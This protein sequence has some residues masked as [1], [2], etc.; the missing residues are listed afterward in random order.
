[1][2][3]RQDMVRRDIILGGQ[4][5]DVLSGGPSEDWIFGGDGNDVL[6]GGLDRQASDLLFGGEGDD[7]FQVICDYLPL[8]KGSD[9]TFLPTF[10]DRFD[11]EEGNDRVL[12]L[13]GDYDRLGQSVPDHLA[14]RYN[15]ILHRYEISALVWD[16]AN[17]RFETNSMTLLRATVKATDIAP[18]DGVIDQDTTLTLNVGGELFDP[19]TIERN[20]INTNI[21]HLVDDINDALLAADMYDKVRAG[22]SGQ[23]L[24]LFA[25]NFVDT[26]TVVAGSDE[27]HFDDAQF[28]APGDVDAYVQTY[29]FYQAIDV[30]RT[31]IDTRAG[32]DEVRGDAEYM[33]PLADGSGYMPSEYGIKIGNFQEG[34]HI[35]SLDIRGGDGN[36]RLF[37]GDWHDTIDGGGGSDFVAGGLGD[38]NITGGP[39]AD[40]LLG[41]SGVEPDR[42]EFITRSG[43]DGSNN[44][45]EFASLIGRIGDGAVLSDLS[46]NR[47]DRGDWYIIPTPTAQMQFGDI[48]SAHLSRKMISSI[49]FFDENGDPDTN[50]D[51][52]FSDSRYDGENYYLFAAEQDDPA[53]E[54]SLVPVDDFSGVPG[55]YMLHVVNPLSFAVRAADVPDIEGID[56]VSSPVTAA[57]TL[58]VDG[59]ET[60][61][62][63][64]DV[65]FDSV[66]PDIVD[67]LN[68]KFAN[69]KLDASDPEP[70]ADAIKISSRVFA[71]EH[72]GTLI[73][74]LRSAGE[75]Q[76]NFGPA[77]DAV[78][79]GF[80][81]G[82]D[83][84]GPVDSMGTY[85]ITFDGQVDDL[86]DI[87]AD[88]ADLN[89]APVYPGDQAA[90]IPVG[91]INND[92]HGDFIVSIRDTV[93]DYNDYLNSPTDAHPHEIM[94]PSY[95]RVVF[96]GPTGDITPDGTNSMTLQL[97]GPVLADSFGV[98]SIFASPGDYDGDGVDDL[99]VLVTNASDDYAN[100]RPEFSQTGLYVMFGQDVWSES[101]NL[102]GQADVVFDGFFRATSLDGIGD[103]T[104]DGIDD[105]VVGEGSSGA[106]K[107]HL[108]E[109]AADRWGASGVMLHADFENDDGGF[110]ADNQVGAIVDGLWHESTGRSD[111]P[112]HS[113]RNS[114]YFGRDED[115]SGGG[116]YDVGDTAG[117]LLTPTI[118]ID[119]PTDGIQ[120][121][122]NYFIE[123]ERALSPSVTNYD[124]AQ[125]EI[126]VNGGAFVP[127]SNNNAA[128]TDPSEHWRHF[129]IE[130]GGSYTAGQTLR[131]RF[132][133][134]TVD[135]IKN[136]YEGWYVDDVTVRQTIDVASVTAT[137]LEGGLL[138]FRTGDVTADGIN[139]FAVVTPGSLLFSIPTIAYI[140]PGSDV[141]GSLPSGSITAFES[142]D[143]G[144]KTIGPDLQVAGDLN[145]D[146]ADDFLMHVMKKSLGGSGRQS[147]IVLGYDYEAGG[148]FLTQTMDI[149]LVALGDISGD[150][151]CDLAGANTEVTDA[152]TEDGLRIEHKVFGVFLSA[153]GN[154]WL[155]PSAFNVPDMI[156]EPGQAEYFNEG[157]LYIRTGGLYPLG[158]LN[159]DG[160]DDF[161]MSDTLGGHSHVFYGRAVTESIPDS[162]R[163]L[164]SELYV[165]EL[166]TPDMFAPPLADG[167]DVHESDDPDIRDAF[168]VDG[169]NDEGHLSGSQGIGDFNRDGYQDVMVY[170]DGFAYIL[171]GPVKLDGTES[172]GTRCE[173]KIDLSNLGRVQSGIGD[174]DGDG[175]D[176][177]MFIRH[178]FNYLGSEMDY[179]V[180]SAIYGN[181]DPRRYYSGA[182]AEDLLSVPGWYFQQVVYE[183]EF[184]VHYPE[185]QVI[186]LDW[187]NKD[188]TEVLVFSP[189][190]DDEMGIYGLL[191]DGDNVVRGQGLAAAEPVLKILAGQEDPDDIAMSM[192]GDKWSEFV[193]EEGQTE[194]NAAVA[195]VN[196]D[197]KD[198][199][200]MA[201]PNAWDVDHSS[202]H[203]GSIGRVYLLEGG[204]MGTPKTPA[205][206]TVGDE[207]MGSTTTSTVAQG[208]GFGDVYSIGDLNLDAYD[209]FAVVS[210]VE[211]LEGADGAAFVYY[212]SETIGNQIDEAAI[213]VRRAP[214][215]VLSGVA[216]EGPMYVTSG[217]FDSDDA[218]DLAIGQTSWEMT[219]G[220]RV[221]D[222]Q[223]RG[224]VHVVWDPVALGDEIVLV[225]G[226]SDF[227]GDG[228][229]DVQAVYGQSSHDQFGMLSNTVGMDVNV[230]Y[231]DDLMIGSAMA[232]VVK[233]TTLADA[234]K[235]Y[236]VYGSPRRAELAFDSVELLSNRSFT[237][238]GGVIVDPETGQP[239]T[240]MDIDGNN[241]GSL[242]T[243]YYTLHDTD[244]DKWYRFT[245]AGD[246]SAGDV[247]RLL[248]E[249]Y[250][251]RVVVFE[252]AG[253]SLG[254]N[255]SDGVFD[256]LPIAWTGGAASYTSVFE[257]DISSLL[258]SLTDPASIDKVELV[259]ETIAHASLT[260][261]RPGGFVEANG[262]TFFLAGG[263]AGDALWATDGTITGTRAL[264]GEDLVLSSDDRE[265]V[266]TGALVYFVAGTDGHEELWASDGSVEGTVCI[267][268]ELWGTHA[269]MEISQ[270]TAF[271][272]MAYFEADDGSGPRLYRTVPKGG[273]AY[274]IAQT[275]GYTGDFDVERMI[276]G[277]NRLYI[278]QFHS[279]T[280]GIDTYRIYSTTGSTGSLS[281]ARGL[282]FYSADKIRPFENAA[283][284]D[285][286]V[287]FTGP[288]S[289]GPGIFGV[290]YRSDG[291]YGGTVRVET[292]PVDYMPHAMATIDDGHALA[293][294][295]GQHLYVTD[296]TSSG[297]TIRKSYIF[298][299]F[300]GVARAASVDSGAYL[301]I[302]GVDIAFPTNV[303][304]V[305]VFKIA[306][307]G[308]V[309]EEWSNS[310]GWRVWDAWSIGD[311][312]AFKL[313]NVGGGSTQLRVTNGGEPDVMYSGD[314]GQ[315]LTDVGVGGGLVYF[316]GE[317]IGDEKTVY[318]GS[319]RSAEPITTIGSTTGDVTFEVLDE[320]GDGVVTPRDGILP[321]GTPVTFEVATSSSDIQTLSADLTDL[322]LEY[323]ADGRS[324]LRAD[325]TKITVR[326]TSEHQVLMQIAKPGALP[327]TGLAVS[328]FHGVLADLYNS[329]GG[330]LEQDMGAI[331]M[332]RLEAGTYYL[333]VFNPDRA[334]QVGDVSFGIQVMAP[335]QGQAHPATDMDLIRGGDGPDILEG[336][337]HLD[338][339][340]GDSGQDTFL[341]ETV[342]V[343]DLEPDE[344][345]GA[346][347]ARDR[348]VS[349]KPAVL[350]PDVRSAFTDGKLITA[351]GEVLGVPVMTI[352]GT[353]QFARPVYA[354]KI[355]S[356]TRLD[357][358]GLGFSDAAGLQYATNLLYLDLSD[359]SLHNEIHD[360]RPRQ[361]GV[362]EPDTTAQVGLQKLVY[363]GLN[364]TEIDSSD[365]E[366]LILIPNIRVLTATGNEITHLEGLV[367]MQWMQWLDLSDN[368]I[369]SIGPLANLRAFRYLSLRNNFVL[370]IGDLVG[371]RII[372]DG[373]WRTSPVVY[374]NYYEESE[375]WY[376]NI[377]PVGSAYRGD[378]S[379]IAAGTDSTAQW[380]FTDLA[381]GEYE[382]FVTWHEHTDQA[383]NATY[384]IVDQDESFEVNQKFAPSGPTYNG[385][386]WRSLGVFEPQGDGSLT[387][388]LN[389]DL[390]DGTLVADGVMVL[391]VAPGAN[392]MRLLDLRGNGLDE[393]SHE[394]YLPRLI[395]DQIDPDFTLLIEP[396]SGSPT[397]ETVIGPVT[398]RATNY[399]PYSHYE[400]IEDVS[401][402]LSDQTGWGMMVSMAGSAEILEFTGPYAPSPYD[403]VGVAAS[404]KPFG[405]TGGS[406]ISGIGF[407]SIGSMFVTDIARNELIKFDP[408]TGEILESVSVLSSKSGDL[409]VDGDRIYMVDESLW[410]IDVHDTDDLSVVQSGLGWLGGT[411][412]T[413]AF[414]I[415]VGPT[416]ASADDIGLYVGELRTTGSGG[417]IQRVELDGMRTTLVGDAGI[418]GNLVDLTVDDDG[419]IYAL[420]Y[421]SLGGGSYEL[422]VQPFDWDGDPIIGGD[423]VLFAAS[424]GDRGRE[425]RI[426]MG[427]DGNVYFTNPDDRTII[428]VDPNSETGAEVVAQSVQMDRPGV[429][430]FAPPSYSFNVAV[431]DLTH[432]GGSVSSS[433]PDKLSLIDHTSG[434][435]YYG[436]GQFVITAR[437][438][439]PG[440]DEYGFYRWS[441]GRG[442][443]LNVNFHVGVGAVYGTK[444]EDIN[445]NGAQNSN[446]PGL[447]NWIIFAD[448]DGDGV[449]DAGE[450][451]TL[452]DAN[453]DYALFDL[454]EGFHVIAEQ[455]Q[456]W[457]AQTQPDPDD[458]MGNVEV[459]RATFED[460]ES[461]IT[462]DNQIGGDADGLWHRTEY[463]SAAD[464]A[465]DSRWSFYFGHNETSTSDGNYFIPGYV[466]TA[467]EILTPW[468]SLA[469]ASGATLSFE[470]YLD[471][472]SWGLPG[473]DLAGVLVDDGTTETLIASR[474]SG[475]VTLINDA[476]WRTATISL[477][478]FAGD[479]IRV[480]FRFDTVDGVD[481]ST[482]GW[483][484]D[485]IKVSATLPYSGARGVVIHDGQFV[486]EDVDFGNRPAIDAG[487]NQLVNEGDQV[488]LTADLESWIANMDVTYI[489]ENFVPA[490]GHFYPEEMTV[491]RGALY[492]SGDA[493][494]GAGRELYV[495]NGSSI[496]LLADLNQTAPDADSNPTGLVV[497]EDVLYFAADNGVDGEE[498]YS[499]E[500][501]DP[502][503]EIIDIFEGP[504]GSAPSDMFA[505]GDQLYFSAM[506][507]TATGR[508][509]MAFDGD[510][511]L[512][513]DN[514]NPAKNISSDPSDFAVYEGN[515]YFAATNSVLVGSKGRE[516]HRYNGSAVTLVEDYNP[517]S[518][519]SNPA[520]LTVFADRLYFT[521]QPTA[522]TSGL[523]YYDGAINL[524]TTPMWG[525]NPM[526]SDL[527][528]VGGALYLSA[529]DYYDDRELYLR[530]TKY[531]DFSAININDVG[532]SSPTG[533]T[534]YDGGLYFGAND[535]VHGNELMRFYGGQGVLV[536]DIRPGVGWS[537]PSGM[538]EYDGALYFSAFV[539]S[540]GYE[541][542]HL[543]DQPIIDYQWA[544]T[545]TG[546]DVQG[547]TGQN[548]ANCSFIAANDGDYHV[549]LTVDVTGTSWSFTD[550]LDV[551]AYDVPPTI[552]GVV[553]ETSINEGSPFDGTLNIGDPGSDSWSVIVDWGDEDVQD[554][555]VT[556]DPSVPLSHLYAEEG[557][558]NV[559]ITVTDSTDPAAT[560]TGGLEITVG[561]T[562]PVI[563]SPLVDT[564]LDEGQI[565]DYSATADDA[566]GDD[567]TFTWDFGDDTG[568]VIGD[569]V[570]HAFDDDGLYAA[571]VTVTDGDGGW[572]TYNFDVNVSNADPVIMGI[573]GVTVVG[574]GEAI[575]LGGSADDPGDDVL[576]FTWDFGDD[577]G[578]AT[579]TEVDYLYADNGEYT[580][581]LTVTDG[582]GG[583]D[584]ASLGVTVSNLPP[585]ITSLTGDTE[586]LEGQTASFN[587]LADDPH[588]AGLTYSWDFDDGAFGSGPSVDHTYIDDGTYTVVLSVSDG[589]DIVTDTL[590]VTVG[591]V[592][593][594][595]TSLNGD[596]N[597]AEGVAAN[598]LASATT[599]GTDTLTYTWDFGDSSGGS[600]ATV[601]HPYAD[602][603]VYTVTLTVTDQGAGEATA[604]FI[605]AVTN[606][607]PIIT[608]TDGDETA[609]EGAG[610]EADFSGSA[611][612]AGAD[613]LTYTWN[614]GDGSTPQNGT[615]V[616]HT[617]L[618]SGS[619]T[620]SLVV[621][622]G[623]GG[624]VTRDMAVT[625][626]AN[627]PPTATL[628]NDGP[629][630]EGGAA[631]VSFTSPSDPSP[632]DADEL[633][634]SFDF[635]NDNDFDDPGDIVD[636]EAL[637][638]AM[639][640]EYLTDG[641]GSVTVRG[642][643]SDKDGGFTDYTT[644]VVVN[645]TAPVVSFDQPGPVSI[646][647]DEA[648]ALGGSF[649]D[650]GD[651]AWVAEVDYDYNPLDPDWQ[652]LALDG[653][654]FSLSHIYASAA[655]YDLAVKVTDTDDGL[656]GIGVIQIEVEPTRI[657]ARHVFYN[658]STW[659]GNNPL[660][661]EADDNAIAADKQV[662]LPGETATTANYTSYNRG[663]NGIMVDMDG[664]TATPTAGDFNIR[665]NEAAN[666][667]TW[668]AGPAPI[669][670]VRPG[671][672]VSGSDRV[673]LTWPDGAIRNQWVEVTVLSDISG[674]NLG[675]AE[676]DVFYSGNAVGDTD[677]DGVVGSSDY[678]TLVGEFGLRGGI[679]ALMADL[680][681][682]SRVDLI[683]FAIM[684]GASGN[685]VLAPT[686]PAAPETSSA[687]PV[688]ALQAVGERVMGVATPVIPIVSQPFD[689][690]DAND[691]SIATTALAP[692]V[693]LLVE[694]PSPTNYISGS[695]PISVGSSAT[696]F[697]RAAMA[698]YDP[699]PLSD[700]LPAGDADDLLAD[701]LAESPLAVPL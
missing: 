442:A 140:I 218:M 492:F 582:D 164:P 61:E 123:T 518:G 345:I 163:L 411:M 618:D 20:D 285:G 208:I 223:D 219:D 96:G 353:I 221:I 672:G 675:L 18:T 396:N 369:E 243:D 394:I 463:G 206:V 295:A 667:D 405:A 339:V 562:N 84:L 11:G 148:V 569:S 311:Q 540:T 478:A 281:Y 304:R 337:G 305:K 282:D 600:G 338:R 548:S 324:L 310:D 677:G 181:P 400:Y 169:E 697:Y 628:S 157:D 610:G 403:F 537:N 573:S 90:M 42:F 489:V 660:P 612:D 151:K 161:G 554:L 699:R 14:I 34:A 574:E 381:P 15:R 145:D 658:N 634:Y 175:F 72:Q 679:G 580:V 510:D 190:A 255:F 7:T 455:P 234:G 107:V 227:D 39:G 200:L 188:T 187:N 183:P 646:R 512:L 119:R 488:D 530:S 417:T 162:E 436:T 688:A 195:D 170:E 21:V 593:P 447:E 327:D 325:R 642:R 415:D 603:G 354:G 132:N 265:M 178:E 44:N 604:D 33:F 349:D 659:D 19:I 215:G 555:G 451:F 97:P 63:S 371:G 9:D 691:D 466:Q 666:P 302:E 312:A 167:L 263:P 342:E 192:F 645:P 571:S 62:V 120:V 35:A 321:A 313:D 298:S 297:T 259:L 664:L 565:G 70:L 31:V 166:A 12:Y 318:V 79:L 584:T 543:V 652:A 346:P 267:S 651:D 529:C 591:N 486:T 484:V 333:R 232:N 38:D 434:Y 616:S 684:R 398:N 113:G 430:A 343:R 423:N 448:A 209:D 437:D 701:I 241:D 374:D 279:S 627:L 277:D 8:L 287:Y 561:N 465:H 185:V 635:N 207:Y 521:V 222:R 293:Y 352:D 57:F 557:V 418:D 25:V 197:G 99:V 116:D 531:D 256:N 152:L 48:D 475:G 545:T 611:T 619:F 592:D 495:Y 380:S 189:I 563:T 599:P 498:L 596:S 320:S 388:S 653:K 657:V 620:A 88:G 288:Y 638:A 89:T 594:T 363:L 37:G 74:C 483:F 126:S 425:A 92:G 214:D 276:A 82:Q 487:D 606:A 491:Y 322:I 509:L 420:A 579:G 251:D 2:A 520:E 539:P 609:Q 683:D 399:G 228:L 23:Y 262:L 698:E 80:D 602:D 406:I 224:V 130:L 567:L 507:S 78:V 121:S 231:Y 499:Y 615:A 296:G 32:D 589:D 648:L 168:R 271:K 329:D 196:A 141:P 156:L 485:E 625:V 544:V 516:L 5:H 598:F 60:G 676:N 362:D 159:D 301:V 429:I 110:V 632:I 700:D 93:G 286:V 500:Y 613:I 433:E 519:S 83:N 203:L 367:E 114:W 546:G 66:V 150:G 368:L 372:D 680:T 464:P 124:I 291:T 424:T 47:G 105:L 439:R 274:H 551:Y 686:I 393:E 182:D 528:V 46:F 357:L 427:P 253:G 383:S 204:L 289:P 469:D 515:L 86:T 81:P 671:D 476:S 633:L 435:F 226:P 230:D 341:A 365:L 536:S 51:A 623:D 108:I 308:A 506:P 523:V 370:N 590:V 409:A 273:N 264:S 694:S 490:A 71:Y 644:D 13:G 261:T 581:M 421:K 235:V 511:V 622:D 459:F 624:M 55:F 233:S 508:E 542:H 155:A 673:T 247:L 307:S 453:G 428:S 566:G 153:P 662:L 160:F 432:F 626:V 268:R 444:Y 471:V 54:L 360:L 366:D 560:V 179:F 364:D 270:L 109:G 3:L 375:R 117:W 193:L 240:F 501:K 467:G 272:S 640:A 103:F 100:S 649:T 335:K 401:S 101:V 685:S 198:D 553:G 441:R 149:S 258:E 431:D 244:T 299:S 549:T 522:A 16:I 524:V 300:A 344:A 194:L 392:A 158:D 340:F 661:N 419:T 462:I 443:E 479:D 334:D 410:Q 408:L 446:E 137:T 692:A 242:D 213:T 43:L 468:I 165:F 525:A 391:S 541:L 146:G 250:G 173:I 106:L 336:H 94:G 69:Q 294:V 526:P 118:T 331:D 586:I 292:T 306:D 663:I 533:L 128:I 397:W 122:F 56:P 504:D 655:T 68:A 473:Y 326:M 413:D 180:A 386:P 665:V 404:G 102:T 440:Q 687:A 249:A 422:S 445:G 104:G 389:G 309:T 177:L 559:Q 323:L 28:A 607:A 538:V 474:E 172:I 347:A 601:A 412:D 550:S 629:V 176:D 328:R 395:A 668:S 480:I 588:D 254:E 98:R 290:L 45:L 570:Q 53:E 695:Q 426:E 647:T 147:T 356:L 73:F 379:F 212:G 316:D 585:T 332:R 236:A 577:L 564:V 266:T 583:I 358:S 690:S 131:F 330:V 461:A 696:T 217:D 229:V 210:E 65:A 87:P 136:Y 174:I 572:F 129:K 460:G 605:V 456:D 513:V 76:I 384:G 75:L 497:F 477:S 10:N 493:G 407:D 482:E 144:A 496:S 127:R 378:Y 630:D 373:D 67:A 503:P 246:G 359:N 142:I 186:V 184:S 91:D 558:Y 385:R 257:F 597:V 458:P 669:V 514:I 472:N 171:L 547:L 133:F 682:D 670:T 115:S 689:D 85:R 1:M 631:A 450:Q 245:I 532:S 387:V 608:V 24:T 614:F 202:T 552:A 315:V 275:T 77:D 575:S 578:S 678:E 17:Q 269:D 402:Y 390:A 26:V 617:Y 29:A 6:T 587:A 382:L 636:G 454:D 199:L 125:L 568:E 535:G 693:D 41:N 452:T 64:V 348:L 674:G 595:I 216:I 517:G 494:D 4:G 40:L 351:V 154:S 191:W 314:Y 139:D 112:A 534:E 355:N 49:E 350:D 22:F 134:D 527:T 576:T 470:Y 58:T 238:I 650:P 278:S 239:V 95:A 457:A 283:I 260:F 639:P 284:M 225:D 319:G 27:L 50:L 449:R 656:A 416:P 376:R 252:G 643:I 220:A 30:E 211:G 377:N 59:V 248:N 637:S 143:F 361:A 205:L 317:F 438:N 52:L 641:A 681:G 556:A 280:G 505:W 135:S 201:M 303:E 111:D 502:A 654:T 621:T 481:N 138:V 414:R 36:D 237:G